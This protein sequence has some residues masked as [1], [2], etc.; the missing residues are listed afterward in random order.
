MSKGHARPGHA[1]KPTR[2][3]VDN[4]TLRRRLGL[5][6]RCPRSA[7]PARLS[8]MAN[9]NR[10]C[11][12]ELGN[13]EA[14]H[15]P[16]E[17]AL[18]LAPGAFLSQPASGPRLRLRRH[19]TWRRPPHPW[20]MQLLRKPTG[21]CGRLGATRS[22]ARAAPMIRVALASTCPG[23]AA[24]EA[25]RAES[26]SVQ[27]VTHGGRAPLPYRARPSGSG[28]GRSRCQWPRLT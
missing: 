8:G 28:C 6:R 19:G 17:G 7:A 11:Y 10:T 23:P 1:L 2:C 22:V 20:P 4:R 9:E 5:Q 13:R 14:A 16:H 3:S 24:T 26:E 15:E 12:F 25:R 18:N 21:S 27:L